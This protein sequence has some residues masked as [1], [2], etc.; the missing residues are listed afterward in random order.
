M[1]SF[2]SLDENIDKYYEGK[3][4]DSASDEIEIKA[5]LDK[6]SIINDIE[7]NISMPIDVSSIV[8][9]GQR[10]RFNKKLKIDTFKF[11]LV[12]ILVA[13]SI[14]II[15]IKISIP[16]VLVA[17]FILMLGLLLINFIILKKKVRSD[18]NE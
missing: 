6:M 12:A 3:L 13:I 7:N 4:D 17:Q 2:K 18:I 11:L 1:K 9:E 10:V 5:I 8:E 16:V 14:G 15:C